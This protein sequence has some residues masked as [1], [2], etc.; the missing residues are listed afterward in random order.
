MVSRNWTTCRFVY[1]SQHFGAAYRLH[2]Q[3]S[4]I[5]YDDGDNKIVLKHCS[6]LP[7]YKELELGSMNF[8]MKLAGIPIFTYRG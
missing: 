4:T 1:R 7:K 8:I 5:E 3:C 2:V 6:H